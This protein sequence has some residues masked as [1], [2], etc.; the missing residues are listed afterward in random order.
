MVGVIL[1]II[2]VVTF[3]YAFKTIWKNVKTVSYSGLSGF[4]SSWL[5]QLIWAGFIAGVVTMIAAKILESIMDFGS[6]IN[7]GNLFE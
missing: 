3:Y 4:F 5:S 7:F 2:F 6:G 1:M